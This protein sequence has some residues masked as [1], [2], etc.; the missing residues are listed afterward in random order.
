MSCL[1]TSP[2]SGTHGICVANAYCPSM[3]DIDKIMQELRQ[4]ADENGP[5]Y[6]DKETV[7]ERVKIQYALLY[8]N[9]KGTVAERDSWVKRHAAY[10]K[11][12]DYK[13][14]CY[15]AWKTAESR[16]KVLLAEVE[17]WRSKATTNR[18]QDK[19]QW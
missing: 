6:G 15:V 2:I 3:R 17:I 16:F 11:I 13:R 14:D 10:K 9:T 18:Q 1:I 7:D 8:E 4:Q 5:V 19:S 12:I